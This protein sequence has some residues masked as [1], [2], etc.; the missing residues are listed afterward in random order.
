MLCHDWIKYE[1]TAAHHSTKSF[2]DECWRTVY[3]KACLSNQT[4][5]DA[6]KFDGLQVIPEYVKRRFQLLHVLLTGSA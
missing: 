1:K 5:I 6:R 2:F 3:G 4:M